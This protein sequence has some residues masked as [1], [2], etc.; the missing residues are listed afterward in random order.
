MLR[1]A[2][3]MFNGYEVSDYAKKMGFLDYGTIRKSVDAIPGE[4]VFELDGW[5]Q[6]SGEFDEDTEFTQVLLVH[7]VDAR[8][9]RQIDE[10][11]FY[12]G[13]LN[14]YAWGITHWGTEWDYVLTNVPI[15][16]GY[17]SK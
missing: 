14:L 16:C 12:N 1:I 10:I 17:D 2:G 15:N 3:T 5:E 8:M 7:P 6:E 13:D 11:I 4:K 9:L